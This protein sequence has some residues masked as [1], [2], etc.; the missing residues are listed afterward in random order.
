MKNLFGFGIYLF[1]LLFCVAC[2]EALPMFEEEQDRLNFYVEPKKEIPTPVRKSFVYDPEDF[3]RDTI[4]VPVVG[5]GFVRDYDRPIAFEQ[6]ML[7]P[8]SVYNA[9]AGV[10]YVPFDDPEVKHL[11]VLPAGK[12]STDVPIIVLRDRSLRDTSSMLRLRFR[13]NE[14]FKLGDLDRAEVLVEIGDMPM[15][16]KRFLLMG[17]YGKVKHRFLINTFGLRFDDEFFELVE[18]DPQL[19]RYYNTKAKE[20]L[21]K[22][23][24]ER[25]TQGLGPL[26]EADGTEVKFY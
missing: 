8:D 9:E 21:K 12:A 7:N 17:T 24:A 26:K 11:M 4:Y 18:K 10:H 3:V 25:A 22:L 14:Y 15:Q 20:E 16:P 23:N 1:L 6:V 2:E 13:E 5:M 19:G